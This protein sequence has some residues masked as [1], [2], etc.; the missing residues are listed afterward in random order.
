[1]RGAC[2]VAISTPYQHRVPRRAPWRQRD[3]RASLAMTFARNSEQLQGVRYSLHKQKLILRC[4]PVRLQ[5]AWVWTAVVRELD[6]RRGVDFEVRDR[7]EGPFL[8][9]CERL[10]E[11]GLYRSDAYAVYLGG[12]HP[13]DTWWAKGAP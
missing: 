2:A 8:R 11:A 5:E 9:L 4:R 3:C 10:P 6:G 13:T 7:S 12:S 1:M